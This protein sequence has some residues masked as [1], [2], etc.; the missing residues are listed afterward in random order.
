MK[1]N[2]EILFLIEYIITYC[3]VIFLLLVNLEVLL[4]Y[5]LSFYLVK[6]KCF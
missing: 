2:L 1:N 3:F 4:N 6:N 5:R